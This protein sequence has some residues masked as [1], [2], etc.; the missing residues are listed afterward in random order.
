MDHAE[1]KMDTRKYSNKIV[2]AAGAAWNKLHEYYNKASETT[3]YITTILDP[4]WKIKYFQ[5][6]E[7]EDDDDNSYYRNAKRM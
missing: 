1:K 4:R 2:L 7:Y 5:D 6:W 3:H